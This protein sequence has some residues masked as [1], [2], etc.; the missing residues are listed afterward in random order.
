MT[1]IDS[2]PL[3]AIYLPNDQHYARC[4]SS[5]SAASMPLVTSKACFTEAMYFIGKERGWKGHSD[6][7]QLVLSER[8]E[9]RPFS[10]DDLRR[11]HELMQQY[12]D[13][14]MDLAD[15]SLVVLAENL[16]AGL[17]FTLDSHFRAYRLANRR[18]LK[19]VPDV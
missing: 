3:A 6:A 8:L 12:R 11:M 15:A 17:V 14:P 5:L 4:V 2:G 1:L 9:V 10:N 18:F 19:V 16:G 13:A 7:W